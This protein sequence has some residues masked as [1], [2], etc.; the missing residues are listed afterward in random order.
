MNDI[1]IHA[2]GLL[3]TSTGIFAFVVLVFA[4]RHLKQPTRSAY[5][6]I[7]I[8]LLFG[9]YSVTRVWLTYAATDVFG[10]G[11]APVQDKFG[12][13]IA[14][15][16]MVPIVGWQ[17]LRLHR[18]REMHNIRIF[19]IGIC[20]TIVTVGMYAGNFF[21]PIGFPY[22]IV[23]TGFGIAGFMLPGFAAYKLRARYPGTSMEALMV[24]GGLLTVI[25]SIW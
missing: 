8:G 18:S 12:A 15:V 23:M 3:I 9:I 17:L 4:Q 20:C 25:V 6:W 10:G 2:T 5:R 16:L 22:V 11:H 13:L 14:G 24:V 7:A 1:A 21:Q 19:T